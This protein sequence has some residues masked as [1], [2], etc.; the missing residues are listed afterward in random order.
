MFFTY[1]KKTEIFKEYHHEVIRSYLVFVSRKKT[2][3]NSIL[4]KKAVINQNKNFLK[5]WWLHM[6]SKHFQNYV[7]W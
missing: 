1:Q 4:L 6:F 7:F 5:L 2:S 3:H